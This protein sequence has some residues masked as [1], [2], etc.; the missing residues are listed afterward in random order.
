M[1][2]EH[3]AN[4]SVEKERSAS[5]NRRR[6]VKA[7]GATS[8][9]AGIG[10][11]SIDNASAE[12]QTLSKPIQKRLTRL[13]QTY[14][15]ANKARSAFEEHGSRVLEALANYRL[16]DTPSVTALPTN[17]LQTKQEY[18]STQQGMAIDT[19]VKQGTP[20]AHIFTATDLPEGRLVAVVQPERDVS[21]ATLYPNS[22]FWTN[23]QQL[24]DRG[25]LTT[26]M[27]KNDSDKPL[28]IGSAG[29]VSVAASSSSYCKSNDPCSCGFDC[30]TCCT[31]Y[32]VV[33]ECGGGC[34]DNEIR[35]CCSNGEQCPCGN[36]C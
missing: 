30:S 29:S 22:D 35:G 36:V 14:D 2:R 5:V 6:F 20:T 8:A 9:T 33:C 28:F 19:F 13:Q 4:E 27:R 32:R 25:G 26:K 17:E 18:I 31:Y 34:A 23:R 15:T 3:E 11:L 24:S 7:M 10:M 1:S 21:Y 16:I 12:E